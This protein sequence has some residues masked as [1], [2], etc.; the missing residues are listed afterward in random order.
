MVT[1]LTTTEDQQAAFIGPDVHKNDPAVPDVLWYVTS[2]QEKLY[3]MTKAAW[4]V[5][6]L[7]DGC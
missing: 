7:S 4:I 3:I 2:Q 1:L 6:H 5:N